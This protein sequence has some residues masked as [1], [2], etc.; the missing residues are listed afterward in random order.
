MQLFGGTNAGRLLKW[1]KISAWTEVA[2]QLAAQVILC[3]AGFNGKVYGGTH[4]GKLYEWNSVDAW[5]EVAP[6][7]SVNTL[8]GLVVFNDKLYGSHLGALL[9]WNGTNAWV[10]VAPRIGALVVVPLIVFNDK[11]YGGTTTAG[12]GGALLEW[13]GTNAW[14]QVAPLL[15][16]ATFVYDFAV[17]GSK[18]YGGMG[19]NNN[20]RLYE[21][22]GTNAWV[23]VAA[24]FAAQK[25]I[26]S[27]TVLDDEIY[28]GTYN[29][30]N[31]QEWNGTDAWTTAATRSV[32]ATNIHSLTVLNNKI[33]GG[34]DID[35]RLLEWNGTD[36]W[37]VAA[38][39]LGADTDINCLLATTIGVYADGAPVDKTYSRKLV[40]IG[41]NEVWCED[42]TVTPH[43]MSEVG[44]ANEGIDTSDVLNATVA[45]QKLFIV[46]GTNKKVLDFV[47]TKITTD[48]ISSGANMPPD[49]GAVITAVGGSGASMI[50]DYI[51]AINGACTIYGK[52]TTTATF[53]STDN[54][55]TGTNPATSPYAGAISIDLNADE[56]A[57]PHW[58][59]YTV[60]GADATNY[61]V[62]P[63]K[64]YQICRYR[65]RIQ[66]SGDPDY[67]HQWY[68]SRQLN[69]YDFLHVPGDAQSPV[70][71]NDAD[72][73]IVGDIIKVAISYSDDYLIYGCANEIWVMSG[74]AAFGGE[75]NPLD[76]TTGI[77]GDRAWCWDDKSN[78]YMV[79][80]AGLL[81]IPKGFGQIENLTMELYPDFI[82]DL[83]FDSSLHRITLA[84]NPEEHGIHIFKT[85]LADG[86]C[87]GWWYDLRVEGLFPDAI[88]TAMGIYSAFYYPSETPAYKKLLFGCA[89]GYIKSF[90]KATL[91]DDGTAITSYV[92][93]APLALSTHPRKD[94][95]IKN[96]DI[97]TGIGDTDSDNVTCT[98]HVART[99]AQVIKKLNDGD[100]ATF[101]K[102]FIAPNWTK[103]NLD[104]RSVRGQW[105]AIVLTN[106]ALAE[107]WSMERLTVDS[108]E[109]G[110]SL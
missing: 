75:L 109:V 27:L 71:G 29:L 30:A 99:A 107:S 69:P 54:T 7:P 101:T 74:D 50:V 66:L 39:Q 18:L 59:N 33:Y 79:G 64:V 13:N 102:T 57:P 16:T 47:N 34:T 73:S 58:Y 48:D 20:A 72:C 9:E 12:G 6:G 91:N 26:K 94:G 44:A 88:P 41:Y 86:T 17:L 61:G 1:D 95:I 45:F 2:P 5:T 108:K 65:G 70:A 51:T 77:L 28:G 46:N 84:F 42:I 36:A 92:G 49:F 67:P 21:W 105:G 76:T 85:T 11:I 56:V 63:T 60:Y 110:R 23:S 32:G 43:T 96:I 22:N 52:R 83:A 89:D 97:V 78:L 81:R 93:F 37:T 87:T 98:V 80:T 19:G 62:I 31:L 3:L 14:V 106:S 40:S 25:S 55:V 82:T 15:G 4:Q 90:D 68:Q 103:S 10:E 24:P 104:R 38:P 35:G 100:T 8:E 53:L